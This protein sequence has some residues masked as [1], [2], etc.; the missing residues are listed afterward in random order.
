MYG[1]G[2]DTKCDFQMTGTAGMT[3]RCDTMRRDGCG[4][5][6][7]RVFTARRRNARRGSRCT[8]NAVRGW[9]LPVRRGAF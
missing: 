1:I 8:E 9:P 2:K 7:G 5:E 4:Q 3:G 6:R